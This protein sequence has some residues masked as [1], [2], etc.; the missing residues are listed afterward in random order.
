MGAEKYLK[1]RLILEPKN[2][3]IINNLGVIETIKGDF[4]KAIYYYEQALVLKYDFK[5]AKQNLNR[6]YE[7][8]QGVFLN[9]K[10]E[11]FK[12]K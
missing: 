7:Q 4:T 2:H 3:A 12:K 9:F 1:Q 5:L 8:K 6:A 10:F 11:L